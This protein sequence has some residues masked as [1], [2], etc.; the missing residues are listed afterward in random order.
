MSLAGKIFAVI[1][2]IVAVFYAGI[3]AA[4]MSLQENYKQKHADEVALHVATKAKAD[5]D[6][7]DAKA[8]L[9]QTQGVL[10][11]TKKEATSLLGE[12]GQLRTE[13]AQAAA[14]NKF[15][16]SV[17]NDQ[18][19][20]IAA[21]NSRVD[22]YNEDLKAQ[23]DSTDGLTKKLDDANTKHAELLKNRDAVQD[24]LTVRERD[25]TNAIKEVEKL[26]GDLAQSNDMLQRLKEKDIETYT[27]LLHPDSSI[28]PKKVIRGKVT[29]VDKSLGLVII[30]IGQ[31][32]DVLKG[33]SFIVFRGDEYIGKIVVDEVFPDMTATHYDKT[34]MKKDV[35]VGD[36]VTTR[37]SIDL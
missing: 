8:L 13:W 24:L 6:E 7:K 20:Q 19:D 25:L 4:L 37:L 29:G 17:I 34:S 3:T 1:A 36:D 33:Y 28:R 21:L 18:E 5:V 9:D 22:R 11:R 15:A 12:V 30:N 14:I 10:D 2:M 16:M 26:T 31:R 27:A 23:R 32:H 35:E